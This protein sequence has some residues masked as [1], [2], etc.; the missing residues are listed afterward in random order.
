MKK[1]ILVYWKCEDKY[2]TYKNLAVFLRDHPEYN[3]DTITYWITRKGLPYHTN[4]LMLLK[5]DY[6]E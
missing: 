2:E 6:I 4:D 5:C 1:K 3:R